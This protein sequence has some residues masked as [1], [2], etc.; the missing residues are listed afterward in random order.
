MSPSLTP[1]LKAKDLFFCFL[2]IVFGYGGGTDEE[3]YGLKVFRRMLDVAL[4]MDRFAS[5]SASSALPARPA[6]LQ[7]R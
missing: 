7:D 6:L 2:I 5:G 3:T 4:A 1:K